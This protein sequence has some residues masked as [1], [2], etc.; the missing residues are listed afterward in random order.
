[1]PMPDL[2]WTEKTDN[3]PPAAPWRSPSSFWRRFLGA[4]G[5]EKMSFLDYFKFFKLITGAIIFLLLLLLIFSWI[6]G[7][8]NWRAVFLTNNQVYFGHFLW[9][10]FT[11]SITLKDI[12]YL[13]VSQ[14]L[15][16]G[17]SKDKQPEIKIV[18]FG[19]EIHG[20]TDRMVIMK[21]QILFWEDLKDNSPVVQKI[22]APAQGGQASGSASGGKD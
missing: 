19:N 9:T 6:Q 17:D 4:R 13:Q 12:Y 14:P 22:S 21:P 16:Q 20:P 11:S 10:P 2:F 15:Q 18:K 7:Q 5:K 3:P 1:M 8:R